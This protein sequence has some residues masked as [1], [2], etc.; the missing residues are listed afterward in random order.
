L[1]A[2]SLGDAE[3]GRVAELV[4]SSDALPRVRKEAQALI[5]EAV[6]ELEAIELDG[7]RPTLIGLA[8]SAVDRI[9]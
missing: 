1:L 3:V 6:R 5:D 4:T 8:R 7:L 9:S 2:G